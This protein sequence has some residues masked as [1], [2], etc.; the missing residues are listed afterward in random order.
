LELQQELGLLYQ[1]L[2]LNQHWALMEW[3]LAGEKWGA[4]NTSA[5]IISSTTNP[6][7]TPLGLNLGF[8]NK[9]MAINHLNYGTAFI[10]GYK[11]IPFLSILIPKCW[12]LNS[13]CSIF[14]YCDIC[15]VATEMTLLNH[16]FLW[17]M[18]STVSTLM[19]SSNINSCTTLCLLLYI[20]S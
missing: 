13:Y 10:R 9:K 14:C 8:H 12:H 7:W 20:S 1:P 11:T 6:T 19:L 17:H 18:V 16:R 3:L 4:W 2:I 15:L 5:N